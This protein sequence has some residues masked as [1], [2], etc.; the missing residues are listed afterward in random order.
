[1]TQGGTEQG[2][3]EQRGTDQPD[4]E[5]LDSGTAHINQ[6]DISIDALG[7]IGSLDAQYLVSLIRSVPG[8]PNDNVLFRDFLPVLA[9]PRGLRILIDA[10]TQTLPIPADQFDSIA[11]LDARGFLFGPALAARLGKGFIAIRKQ[12]KIPP[13][14][15]GE[16]YT[17]EYGEQTV[18]IEANA[19]TPG[20]RVLIVD[21]LIA[22]GGSAKAAADLV[23]KSGGVV[24][25]FSFVMELIG[26]HGVQALG[27]LPITALT[28]MPA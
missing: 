4:S 6:S 20:E 14:V 2:S 1:M 15:I 3:A 13:P 5:Q 18:E 10:L 17:L 24:A 28:T 23:E 11:G 7:T 25:G 21:D 8:F 26:L 9:D 16:A 22:T 19:I 27:A 12:G